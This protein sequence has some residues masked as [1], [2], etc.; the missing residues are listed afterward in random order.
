MASRSLEVD[1]RNLAGESPGEEG[2]GGRGRRFPNAFSLAPLLVVVVGVGTCAAFIPGL[3]NSFIVSCA[4]A[5]GI[6]CLAA[7]GAVIRRYLRDLEERSEGRRMVARC[8][9]GLRDRGARIF[10]DVG[11]K[12]C[13]LDHVII[14]RRGVFVV[15]IRAVPT[16]TQRNAHA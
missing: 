6:A 8:M 16:R 15:A 2:Q 1:T 7:C 14:S 4:A 13:H 5:A 9:D 11:G 3:R 12:G 10:H